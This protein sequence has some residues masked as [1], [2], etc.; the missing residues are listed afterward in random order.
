MPPK[1]SK[2]IT[3][4]GEPVE[5]PTTTKRQAKEVGAGVVKPGGSPE[6]VPWRLTTRRQKA[7]WGPVV[8]FFKGDDA[9]ITGTW[10]LYSDIVDAIVAVSLVP[11]EGKGWGEQAS[12]DDLMTFA[13]W[14]LEGINEAEGEATASPT[15]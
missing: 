15:S 13:G 5:A 10:Q 7:A 2:V 14:Y 9:S 8:D 4:D 1:Q 12:D 3:Q 6:V 11:I